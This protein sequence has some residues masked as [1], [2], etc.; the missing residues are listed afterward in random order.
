MTTT[1]DYV[2]TNVK[3]LKASVEETR[4]RTGRL[5]RKECRS[6]EIDGRK[7]A[8]T[9]R[10]WNSLYSMYGFNQA[11]FNYFSHDEVFTR[12]QERDD[13]REIRVCVEN[14]NGVEML[15]ACTNPNSG[16]ITHDEML[17]VARMMGGTD[18]KY[19]NGVIES[20]HQPA[21]GSSNFMVGGD[22]FTP[23]LM[24]QTP[25]DGYG[26]PSSY[27]SILRQV[28]SNGMVAMDK[29]F[30]SRIHIGKKDGHVSHSI[31]RHLQGYGNDEGYSAIRQR[32]ASAQTSR[33]SLFEVTDLYNKLIKVKD[34]LSLE[35]PDVEH[36]TL[37][38]QEHG[39]SNRFS[40]TR[41]LVDMA[42]DV[43]S[44]YG[45]ASSSMVNVKK[46]KTLPAKCNVYDLINFAT[47]VATHHA[48]TAG[49]R[50]LHGWVGGL[51]SNE[52]DL[53]GTKIGYDSNGFKD[54]H[55]SA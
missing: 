9:S 24:L 40:I 10:F 3:A 25:I 44:L 49:A 29:A 46:L 54:L 27:L 43:S 1:F 7:T 35:A 32:I 18:I 22:E 52:F 30:Q 38:R 51:I 31:V 36:D 16:L 45:L 2:V 42:G 21:V 47:E 48:E 14:T 55:L 37:I 41:S 13:D 8:P 19:H 39:M 34:H 11:F 28:C 5:M 4:T 23:R 33:A 15:L 12:L 50:S 6:I 26:L 53:E 17:D 20:H